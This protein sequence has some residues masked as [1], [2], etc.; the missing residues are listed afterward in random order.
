M[1]DITDELR[2]F[3][4]GADGYELW[5]PRHK[6]ELTEIAD[7]IDAELVERYVELPKDADGVP[8]HV[9]DKLRDDAE[10]KSE[11]IVQR[12]M[13]DDGKWWV[14]FRGEPGWTSV[15]IHEW[16]HCPSE[17][18]ERIIDDAIMA[19]TEGGFIDIKPLVDRCRALAGDS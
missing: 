11:G 9:R 4:A 10:F 15:A 6:A 3:M 5:C 8:I 1:S 13:F 12:L 2:G 7:R 14:G 17:S 19:G 18:W 16:H